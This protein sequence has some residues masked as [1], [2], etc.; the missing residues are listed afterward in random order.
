MPM[1]GKHPI[2]N[3]PINII[4]INCP[5]LLRMPIPPSSYRFQVKPK[6]PQKAKAK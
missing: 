4:K 3:K 1:I 6:T 5:K 2:T